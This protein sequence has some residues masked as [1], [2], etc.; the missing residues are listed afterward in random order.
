MKCRGN[1]KNAD[2]GRL[3]V[4]I[5]EQ[6]LLWLRRPVDLHKAQH[7]QQGHYRICH[8]IAYA[9]QDLRLEQMFD[10]SLLHPQQHVR[11]LTP[12]HL[13]IGSDSSYSAVANSP[14]KQYQM[15]N[16]VSHVANFVRQPLMFW[17]LILRIS[18]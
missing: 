15:E 14:W 5:E 1:C 10:Q 11:T 6:F 12:F 3:L 18:Q 16:Y 8:H 4:I 13:R 7:N 17:S 2:D 9:T